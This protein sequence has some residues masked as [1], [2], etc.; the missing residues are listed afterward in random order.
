MYDFKA[1]AKLT[2]AIRKLILKF[3]FTVLIYI[4]EFMSR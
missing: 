2:K 4:I 3:E 1:K